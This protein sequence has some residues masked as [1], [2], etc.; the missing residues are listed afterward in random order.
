MKIKKFNESINDKKSIFTDKKLM[1][2]FLKPIS[3][4]S[5]TVYYKA[6]T[7]YDDGEFEDLLPL[8]PKSDKDFSNDF[9]TKFLEDKFFNRL[10]KASIIDINTEIFASLTADQQRGGR[11]FSKLKDNFIDVLEKI[12]SL[13]YDAQSEGYTLSVFMKN[14]GFNAETTYNCNAQI[15]LLILDGYY[16]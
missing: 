15:S 2:D 4:L 16:D 1:K 8:V 7:S 12:E 5:Y 6:Y 13:K 3:N 10:I 14:D 11:Y 9:W